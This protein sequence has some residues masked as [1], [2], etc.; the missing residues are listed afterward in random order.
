MGIEITITQD[1][2]TYRAEVNFAADETHKRRIKLVSDNLGRIRSEIYTY[3]A[4]NLTADDMH[5]DKS[6][7]DSSDFTQESD[8]R[9]LL[10]R[11]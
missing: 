2:L 1:G 3:A 4:Q 9:N 6:L 11:L 8:I 7:G 5:A 10:N